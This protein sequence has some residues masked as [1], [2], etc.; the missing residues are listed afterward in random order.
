[1]E[2]YQ[3]SPKTLAAERSL[4]ADRSKLAPSDARGSPEPD[5]VNGNSDLHEA[6]AN[7]LTNGEP[8]E[9]L[10][11][12]NQGVAEPEDIRTQRALLIS[13]LEA[14]CNRAKALIASGQMRRAGTLLTVLAR[15]VENGAEE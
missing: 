3:P 10:T 6:T 15:G 4:Q 8:A 1:M 2:L 11:A 9:E 7:R 14:T 5:I 12:D 13:H